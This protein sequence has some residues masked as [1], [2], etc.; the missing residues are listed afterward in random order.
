MVACV[1]TR[2]RT[3]NVLNSGSVKIPVSNSQS[4]CLHN[5][6][7]YRLDITHKILNLKKS[8]IRQFQ[9]L[10]TELHNTVLC[11]LLWLIIKESRYNFLE[12]FVRWI[13]YG[14]IRSS[15]SNKLF[16]YSCL[17]MTRSLEAHANTET[18]N[19][20]LTKTA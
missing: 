19:I 12:F 7:A 5:V 10:N 2:V 8:S 13:F 11:I 15:F 14:K 4:N 9:R 1:I 3:I 17:S 16:I 6:D 20:F 18:F